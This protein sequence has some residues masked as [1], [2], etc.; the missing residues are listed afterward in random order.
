MEITKS[1]VEIPKTGISKV[2]KVLRAMF[3]QP[4]GKIGLTLLCVHLFLA[5]FANVLAPYDVAIQDVKA[6]LSAPSSAHWFGTD[7]LGRDVLSRAVFGGRPTLITTFFGTL[8]ALFLG[9][10][11]GVYFGFR[12]GKIDDIAMRIVDAFLAIPWLLLLLLI[13]AIF[14]SATIVMI[15]TLG[16]LYAVAI[17]RIVRGATLDVVAQDYVTAA[18]TRGES[19]FTIV[20]Y[21]LLPNVLDRSVPHYQDR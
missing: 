19:A 10:F 7:N 12:G 8:L 13:I 20:R 21:E 3:A 4:S 9:G 11:F 6:I 18:R 2:G 17:V 15:L 14:G 16:F 1:Q 5:I